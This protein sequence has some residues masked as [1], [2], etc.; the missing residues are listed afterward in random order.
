MGVA[1]YQHVQV[2]PVPPPMPLV[3]PAVVASAP[4]LASAPAP[5][6]APA[7]SFALVVAADPAPTLDDLLKQIQDKQTT[8]HELEKHFGEW[9][10]K[11]QEEKGL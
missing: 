8:V 1:G 9:S 6:P 11:Y 4:A 10:R 5:A 7:P 3:V 2:G